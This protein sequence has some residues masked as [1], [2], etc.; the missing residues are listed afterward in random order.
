MKKFY[1]DIVRAGRVA[2]L[3]GP[4]DSEPAARE[5]SQKA[6]EEACKVDPR[7]H[8]DPYGVVGVT[9]ADGIA[10]PPGKLNSHLGLDLHHHG[11][12]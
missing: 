6:W 2:Y 10:F 3:A 9:L 11:V 1:A 7:A 5:W 8:F 4:F 12:N